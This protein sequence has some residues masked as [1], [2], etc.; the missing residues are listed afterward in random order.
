MDVAVV[1]LGLEVRDQSEAG[2]GARD[3]VEDVTDV[4]VAHVLHHLPAEDQIGGPWQLF[5]RDHISLDESGHV[6]ALDEVVIDHVLDNIQA[7][8]RD[9]L[10]HGRPS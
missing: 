9:G 2:S 6:V 5:E 1:V 10:C 3:E 4:A 7:G 8:V